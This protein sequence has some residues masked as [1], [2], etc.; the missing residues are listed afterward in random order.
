MMT[1][2]APTHA[3][4]LL[5]WNWL[6]PL[7]RLRGIYYGP[8]GEVLRINDGGRAVVLGRNPRP[9]SIAFYP[10]LWGAR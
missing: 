10:S 1:A 8:G 3:A 2:L 5:A 9:W 6:P 7:V 4:D